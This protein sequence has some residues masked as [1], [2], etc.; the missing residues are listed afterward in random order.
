MKCRIDRIRSAIA[1]TVFL[2]MIILISVNIVDETHANTDMSESGGESITITL[3][4]G[5]WQDGLTKK[6]NKKRI[7]NSSEI[8]TDNISSISYDPRYYCYVWCINAEGYLI[9]EEKWIKNGIIDISRLPGETDH[10]NLS[11]CLASDS[12]VYIHDRVTELQNSIEII[13]PEPKPAGPG[14]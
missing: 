10:I 3:E 9:H 1:F 6:K 11:F 7:R 5:L 8:K 2:G 13:K 4:S 12:Q 14:K